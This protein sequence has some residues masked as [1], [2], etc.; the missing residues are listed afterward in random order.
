MNRIYKHKIEMDTG[1]GPET[2]VNVEFCMIGYEEIR[3]LNIKSDRQPLSLEDIESL[4]KWILEDRKEW[5]VIN[6]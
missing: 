3:L 2:E 1:A 6:E 5:E 4:L